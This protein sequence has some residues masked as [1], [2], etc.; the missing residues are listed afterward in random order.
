MAKLKEMGP[1][2]DVGSVLGK[3]GGWLKK[4]AGEDINIAYRLLPGGEKA[5]I[6]E[7][8]QLGG[9][10]L[11]FVPIP[12]AAAV[13]LAAKG[14]AIGARGVI[15]KGGIK[16]GEEAAELAAKGISKKAAK[17][18]PTFTADA[19][20]AARKAGV[21]RGRTAT[22]KELDFVA[23]MRKSGPVGSWAVKD[24]TRR[25][26][27]ASNFRDVM[28]AKKIKRVDAKGVKT[29]VPASMGKAVT[30]NRVRA[31]MLGSGLSSIVNV[32][33]DWFSG[34]G[35]EETGA[36]F[37]N[38]DGAVMTG[39]DGYTYRF[40]PDRAGAGGLQGTN[41]SYSGSWV[42]MS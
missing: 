8:V 6:G 3:A 39:D 29:E 22:A 13:G 35:A 30:K 12:G 27:T 7:A 1:E 20:N 17:A 5:T 38:F 33:S 14:A 23:R 11:T 37:G 2:F 21:T 4:R 41:A 28:L 19:I 42:R 25:G 32:D 31:A 9:D 16:A 18:A 15:A 24:G 10:L 34:G 36:G 26:T 40:V